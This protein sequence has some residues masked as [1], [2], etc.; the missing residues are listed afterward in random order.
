MTEFES[1][2]LT[3]HGDRVVHQLK[4][5]FDV[6]T[7]G[8]YAHSTTS[9]DRAQSRDQDIY[10][11]YFQ[12]PGADDQRK[13]NQKNLLTDFSIDNIRHRENCRKNFAR[14]VGWTHSY[15]GV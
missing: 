8:V 13:V 9:L 10:M 4:S 3:E 12:Q 15:L 7:I 14:K 5:D 2:G 6:K 1:T 11:K